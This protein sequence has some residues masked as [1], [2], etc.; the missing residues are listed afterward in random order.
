MR[1]ESI[2]KA[3]IW[4]KRYLMSYLMT[5]REHCL[6]QALPHTKIESKRLK[7]TPINRFR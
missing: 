4:Q 6:I 5:H 3:L 2:K 1:L 7:L